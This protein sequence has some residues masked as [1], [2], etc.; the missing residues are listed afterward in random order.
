MKSVDAEGNQTIAPEL[1][2]KTT[3]DKASARALPRF[4]AGQN[5]LGKDTAMGL[6][7]TNLGAQTDLLTFTAIEDSG[8]FTTGAGITNPVTKYLNPWS[9]FSILDWQIF[10]SVLSDL[11]SNGWIKFDSASGTTNGFFLIFDADL[12]MLDGANFSDT[13]LTDFVFTEIQ[14][15]GYNKISIINNNS[16]NAVVDFQL[17]GADG[18]IRSSQSRVIPNHGAL[19]ADLF[20]D[21]FLRIEPDAS[22]YILMKSSKKAQSFQVM[23]QKSGD[24]ATLAGQDITAGETDLY[25]PQYVHGD[26]YRTSLSII[27]LDPQPGAVMLRFIREDGVQMGVTRYLA[28]PANG[29]LYIEDPAFFLPLDAAV[30]TAGYIEIVSDGIR[31]AGSTVFGDLN[32]QSFSSALSLAC[33]QSPIGSG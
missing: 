1:T 18:I 29:E 28:I 6:A 23:R 27:N 3:D 9:Q 4:S 7:F 20:S 21:L 33:K 25:S 16:E 5:V 19:T 12:T 11:N 14:T 10:G 2:F 13:Q 8:N 15:D 24:I 31:L 30:I 17:M 22:N 32:R 26:S